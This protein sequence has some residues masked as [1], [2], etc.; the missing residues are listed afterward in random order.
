MTTESGAAAV[1]Q[2]E[3]SGG[4]EELSAAEAAYFSS[5]GE[6][7]AGLLGGL[8][9]AGAAAAAEDAPAQ[10]P[11]ADVEAGDD[12][13]GDDQPEGK[14]KGQF[15]PLSAL[16]KERER[17]KAADGRL[18][19]LSEQTARADERLRLL[20][21]LIERKKAPAAEAEEEAPDA[22]KDPIGALTVAMKRIAS[23]EEQLKGRAAQ[24]KKRNDEA[25]QLT[26]YRDDARTYMAKHADFPDAY[27]Y[28][29]GQRH[30][31]L[32][33]LGVADPAERA[34][35][36][37]RE[38]RALVAEARQAGKS[39]AAT[40]HALAKARGFKP[41]PKDDPKPGGGAA[42]AKLDRIAQAQREAGASLTAAGGGGGGGLTAESL[43][44]MSEDDFAELSSKLGK[45]KLR[46]LMG[47]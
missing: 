37:Q 3:D 43:A 11:G 20:T 26:A 29:I 19:Q 39:P 5:G 15:V 2:V 7:A 4:S 23:L 14:G 38:E 22:E 45:A 42:A 9:P 25:A 18:A 35:L 30:A 41:K 21:E 31:E 24:E 6:D 40:M 47:G 1:A 46:T 13:D 16:H 27:G 17:R 44:A 36:I 10:E 8:D 33:A 34:T 12:D 28:L 32:E